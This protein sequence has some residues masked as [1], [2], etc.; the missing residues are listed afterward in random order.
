MNRSVVVLSGGVGGAKLVDGFAQLLEPQALT[1]AVNTGD[2]FRHLGLYVSPDIDS[3]TYM[4]AN[5]ASAERGWGRSDESW[6][7]MDAL[8]QVGAPDWFQ[9]GDRDLALHLYRTSLL[10]QGL[11]LTQVTGKITEHLGVRH[12][13]LPMTDDVVQTRIRSGANE[14][15]FQEYFVH[16]KCQPVLT[17]YTYAGAASARATQ[18]LLEA[19]SAPELA[20][21]V[22]APSNP[23]LSV[24]PMLA[25]PD[26]A[27][28][29]RQARA[30]VLAVSPFINGA[31]VKGP[32][33]KIFGELG[34]KPNAPSM[35]EFYGDLLDHLLVDTAD[36]GHGAAGKLQLHAD[37]ILMKA[38]ADRRRVARRCLDILGIPT[39][40]AA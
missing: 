37:D 12:R 9:L 13:V 33:A 26:I 39:A 17:G 30:P 20:G 4:L 6:N 1:I 28:A 23:V 7:C 11:G 5:L 19:L 21:I 38:A 18:E 22:L 40:T 35:A 36:I 24:G 29:I 32:A 3:V 14:Y 16:L 2:D 10:E 27:S 8:R 15:P 25:V 34:L 31:A